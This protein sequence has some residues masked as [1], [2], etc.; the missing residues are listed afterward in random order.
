MGHTKA[1][2]LCRERSPPLVFVIWI[3]ES[4]LQPN[5]HDKVR[6]IWEQFPRGLLAFNSSSVAAERNERVTFG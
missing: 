4:R 1:P 6:S 3:L 2:R 5:A